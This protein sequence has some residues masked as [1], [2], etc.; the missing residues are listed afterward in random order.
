MA[1]I[2]KVLML[3]NA[4]REAY[5]C[6][7]LDSLPRGERASPSFDPIARAFRAGADDWLFLAVGSNWLRLGACG[8]DVMA[9]AKRIHSAWFGA[10]RPM[11]QQAVEGGSIYVKL[12]APIVDFIAAFDSGKLPEFETRVA[13][14][15]HARHAEV[16][17]LCGE[18][19]RFFKMK[20]RAP[21]V[22]RPQSPVSAS[23]AA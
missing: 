23:T 1:E 18:V 21:F 5:G 9:L 3:I 22:R 11:N 17:K 12:P 13:D 20:R 15:E 4:A 2:D 19:D 14:H 7:P 8:K 16:V 10:E 6:A